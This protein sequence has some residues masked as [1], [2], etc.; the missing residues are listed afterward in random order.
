MGG[1]LLLIVIACIRSMQ[2][3]LLASLSLLLE[4]EPL[5][6][7]TYFLPPAVRLPLCTVRSLTPIRVPRMTGY[8]PHLFVQPHAAWAC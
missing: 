1:V 8:G 6:V 3:M 4:G 7:K 5:I 2:A